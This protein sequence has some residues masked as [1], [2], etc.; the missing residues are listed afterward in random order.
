[1]T[2]NYLSAALKYNLGMM[3]SHFRLLLEPP[4]NHSMEPTGASH[5]GQLQSVRQ[6]GLAPAA[7]AWRWPPRP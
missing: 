7:H 3:R 1:M 2:S 5:S 6:R 4:P